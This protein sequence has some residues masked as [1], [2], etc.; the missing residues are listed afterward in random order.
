MQLLG[1]FRTPESWQEISLKILCA[2]RFVDKSL[3]YL[4][5]SRSFTPGVLMYKQTNKARRREMFP[6]N[7]GRFQLLAGKLTGNSPPGQAMPFS[8]LC[9]LRYRILVLFSFYAIL[10]CSCQISQLPQA[11]FLSTV[12]LVIKTKFHFIFMLQHEENSG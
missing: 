5:W 6:L 3:E 2:T 11:V 9:T 4:H 12:I 10:Y 1:G 7:D 8:V